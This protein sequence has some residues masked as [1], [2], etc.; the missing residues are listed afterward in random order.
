[1]IQAAT[2]SGVVL[3][4]Q[5]DHWHAWGDEGQLVRLRLDDMTPTH[6]RAT[7]AWLRGHAELLHAQRKAIVGRLYKRGELDDV[8][9]ADELRYLEALDPAVWLEDTPLVRR[10]VQLVP[11]E[12]VRPPRVLTFGLARRLHRGRR[13]WQ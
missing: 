11:R 4:D 9:F 7:L 5:A 3:L 6:R 13:W 8:E 10:L 12:P 2:P 1:V